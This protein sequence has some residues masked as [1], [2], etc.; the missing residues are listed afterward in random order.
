MEKPPRLSEIEAILKVSGIA[1]YLPKEPIQKQIK[2]LWEKCGFKK[3]YPWKHLY[4]LP[5]SEDDSL[6]VDMRDFE[7]DLNNLFKWAVP[8]V[9]RLGY[10]NLECRLDSRRDGDGYMWIISKYD[11]MVSRRSDY[12]TDPALALFWAIYQVIKEEKMK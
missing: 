3:L 9:F 7:P 11:G 5:N 1:S 12:L 10:N 4:T 2:E 6:W 8:K